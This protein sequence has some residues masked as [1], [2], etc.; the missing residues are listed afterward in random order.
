M[1]IKIEK[2]WMSFL[3]ILTLITGLFAGT[4]VS[5]KTAQASSTG[6]IYASYLQKVGWLNPAYTNECS[7]RAG[8]SLRVEAFKLC[9]TDQEYSGSVVYR[10]YCQS[11]G[12][13]NW[14]KDGEVSGT[15]GQ[16]KRMEAIQIKLTGD[17]HMYRVMDGLAGQRMV[18][19]LEQQ[20]MERELR[21]FRLIYYQKIN[22]VQI[23]R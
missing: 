1:D 18:R 8:Y 16:G 3:V 23:I 13:R 14:A 7:G 2:R 11:Y 20:N 17:M 12:W 10:S 15:T 9:L 6:L 22:I 5:E 19:R 4:V 21:L